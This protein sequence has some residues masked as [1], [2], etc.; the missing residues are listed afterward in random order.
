MS[1]F[2]DHADAMRVINA[3]FVD[4]KIYLQESTSWMVRR[5]R[6]GK[7]ESAYHFVITWL[8]HRV[9]IITGDI[10]DTVYSGI[11]HLSNLDDTIRLVRESSM[12]YLTSKSTHKK[13]FDRN[14]TTE[15]IVERAYYE[16]RNSFD[17]EEPS[18]R[19]STR[20][21]RI[22]CWH[23]GN[24]HIQASSDHAAI[25]RKDACRSL[26]S[27]EEITE[28]E[29]VE[30]A[31]DWEVP[32]HSWPASAHWHYEALRTWADLMARAKLEQRRSDA[33]TQETQLDIQCQ[34]HSP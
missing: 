1:H 11:S 10:G 21:N 17:K 19:E 32:C 4:H 31:D 33:S 7:P 6:N 14:A 8:P 5:T 23:I 16:M 22:V 12:D 18:W 30:I 26:M 27:D 24:I 20:M 29:L 34:K 9:L 2:R 15:F 25:A 3:T 28:L 13:E